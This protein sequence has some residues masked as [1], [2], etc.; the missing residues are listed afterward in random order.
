M[1]D[2]MA[3]A[4]A[5]SA[6]GS[7]T[8]M[9][10]TAA[11]NIWRRGGYLDRGAAGQDGQEEVGPGRVDAQRLRSRRARAAPAAGAEQR[12]H[13]DQQRPAALQDGHD[14]AAG[15]AGHAVAEQQRAG[16]GHGP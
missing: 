12:L 15:D 7:V 14:H 5:R 10:P 1:T 11:A 9:P 8:V 13:L 2:A 3:R 4:T 6:A 16:I